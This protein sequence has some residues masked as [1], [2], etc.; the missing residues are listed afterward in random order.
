MYWQKNIEAQDINPQIQE[1]VKKE[2]E[3]SEG[4]LQ[5]FI[6]IKEKMENF[7]PQYNAY[8]NENPLTNMEESQVS[9]KVQEKRKLLCHPHVSYCEVDSLP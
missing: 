1:K 7:S 8:C 9:S 2:L 6:D 3:I 4:E 5:E